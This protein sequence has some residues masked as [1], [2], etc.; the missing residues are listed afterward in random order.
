[1]ASLAWQDS[2]HLALFLATLASS[3]GQGECISGSAASGAVYAL[4]IGGGKGGGP[5]MRDEEAEALVM[6]VTFE[7]LLSI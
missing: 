3:L 2:R 1:M 4:G 5:R 7:L 6:L